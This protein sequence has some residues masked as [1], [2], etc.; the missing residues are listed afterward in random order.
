MRGPAFR[1][2]DDVRYGRSEQVSPLIRRVI[3]ENPSKF[4]YRGTGTY[5]VGHGDVVVIDPGPRLDSHRDALAAAL[6]GE[7]VR[8]ILI[9]HCHSDH[10][11]LAAWLQA[12]TGASTYAFGPHPAPDPKWEELSVG[13]TSGSASDSAAGDGGDTPETEEAIDFEFAPT[14]A[15]GDG[16]R[17]PGTPGLT[18]TG[19]HTPGHTS[20]HMCWA[21]GEEHALFT[22]DHVMGW[23]TT[24]V[25]P[26]DGDMA[27][28]IASL[29]K[30]AGRA[31]AMLWPTHGPPRDDAAAYVA[32]LVDHRL[33]RERGVLDVLDAGPATVREIVAVLYADVREEL[34]KAA[35]MSVW[36]HLLK[37]VAEGE[38]EVPGSGEPALRA[39]YQRTR[40]ISQDR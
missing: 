3:A 17:V 22:G 8:A 40:R 37:L 31:D 13:D 20:N 26:P 23:S 4:T 1:T 19:V 28:Y 30:V 29:R 10:S 39:R 9:T 7:R 5:I 18:I 38:V 34:H 21:L 2:L 35:G 25:S 15:L 33:E 27:D 24:V 12:E 11:P 6:A 36:S 14:V 32:A 16:D